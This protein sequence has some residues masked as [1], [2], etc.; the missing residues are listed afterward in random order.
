LPIPSELRAPIAAVSA[1]D[2]A[3]V[4]LGF[5]HPLMFVATPIGWFA[6]I[7][8]GLRSFSLRLQQVEEGA[9]RP[10]R[11][12]R[13]RVAAVTADVDVDLEV[14]ELAA[15]LGLAADHED[16]AEVANA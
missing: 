2:N 7:E 11:V 8:R 5:P 14:D 13:P 4:R 10:H 6:G 1:L 15:E 3:A 12:P 9:R 16:W